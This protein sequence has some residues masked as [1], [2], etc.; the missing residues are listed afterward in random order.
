MYTGD[1]PPSFAPVGMSDHDQETAGETSGP[2][3]EDMDHDESNT[4]KNQ[5]ADDTKAPSYTDLVRGQGNSYNL[6]VNLSLDVNS[7]VSDTARALSL[8]D[9]AKVGVSQTSDGAAPFKDDKAPNMS[10]LD[11]RGISET[12]SRSWNFWNKVN[13][14]CDRSETESRSLENLIRKWGRASWNAEQANRNGLDE[15]TEEIFQLKKMKYTLLEETRA[16][17]KEF[18][19]LKAEK[20]KYDKENE[21]RK[22]HLED[23]RLR[24]EAEKLRIEAKKEQS[25][26]RQEEKRLRLEDEKIKL[27]KKEFDERI[28]MMDMSVLSE[29]Q[30]L[31]FERL[32]KEIMMKYNHQDKQL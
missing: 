15:K 26:I 11:P 29:M 7:H 10:D 32:Q 19:L 20:I 8:G 27:A 13:N 16:Q 3:K 30:R 24:L 31:Y 23:E 18:Y 5:T 21:E 22:L 2:S 1:T 6:D 9:L 12:G 4:A 17:K 14:E 28:M 25:K